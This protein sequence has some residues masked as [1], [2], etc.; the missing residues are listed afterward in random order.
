MQLQKIVGVV[1]WTAGVLG[2]PSGLEDGA[3]LVQARRAREEL[4]ARASS[5]P[6][7][8]DQAGCATSSRNW[9]FCQNLAN[10]IKILQKGGN[11]RK[12]IVK[13]SSKIRQILAKFS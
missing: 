11:F 4:P 1:E 10:F 13:I 6:A 7:E 12:K 3:L 9:N 5:P 8:S 2:S